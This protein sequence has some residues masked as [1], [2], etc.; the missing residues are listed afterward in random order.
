V[1][2]A[3]MT[4]NPIFGAIIIVGAFVLE[5]LTGRRRRS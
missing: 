2:V 1:L 3:I 4:A 5:R